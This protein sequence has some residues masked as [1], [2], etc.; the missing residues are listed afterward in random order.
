MRDITLTVRFKLAFAFGS[1]AIL[2]LLLG[3]ASGYGLLSAGPHVRP[4]DRLVMTVQVVATFGAGAAAIVFGVWIYRSV[5]SALDRMVAQFGTVASTLDLSTRLVDVDKRCLRMDEFGRL[6]V[7]FDKLIDHVEKAISAVHASIA[8]VGVAT[9]EIA[10]GNLDLSVRTEQQAASLEQTAASMKELAETI[11]RNAG[12]ARAALG[13]ASSAQE[14]AVRG[15]EVVS[16]VVVM[17]NGVS[18]SSNKIA[19]IIGMIDGIAFQTNILALNAAV[20]AARAG[21]HG[22]GF[23]VVAG[24][25]RTL[26]QRTTSAAREIKDLISESVTQVSAGNELVNRAGTTMRDLSSSVSRVT[27]IM[28]E[29][30]SASEDQSR[31]VEQVSQAIAQMDEVTQRN[32]ALVEENAAAAQS[33]DDQ[34]AKL[35]AAISV[36]K[37]NVGD[38]NTSGRELADPAHASNMYHLTRPSLD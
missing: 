5:C 36:F 32:A 7:E 23:A 27:D 14:I 20:E 8:Q 21:E 25:V 34:A 6:A 24:E 3:S 1:C 19:D 4:I 10:S 38:A 30:A 12:N 17:M 33:L 16:N 2:V 15:T 9:R 35:Q 22:R 37:T 13:F 28:N 26:A 18:A 31:G 11:Q 29:I